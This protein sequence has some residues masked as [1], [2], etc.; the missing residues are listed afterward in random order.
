MS[1]GRSLIIIVGIVAIAFAITAMVYPRLPDQ[2]AS[3]WNARGKV[4]GWTGKGLGVFILPVTML[5]LTM[6]F[7]LLPLIDPLKR[8]IASFRPYYD[9]FI[10]VFLAFL[11]AI[12]VQV[13]LWNLGRQISP[14]RFLPI[15]MGLLIYYAGVLIQHAK[16]NWFIG[17][18]TPWTLSSDHV[19]EKTHLITGVLF[20]I[21][22]ALTVVGIA[23]EEH[24][25]WLFIV[26]LLATTVFSVAY[27]YVLYR[28]EQREAH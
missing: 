14:N 12:Q 13:L 27:S 25:L 8:N 11:L 19:W 3:H 28:N 22:G 5:G 16:R 20:K 2:V 9:T 6:L 23:F 7:M 10:I 17:V 18:R 24:W 26:P 21:C 4:D 1:T 15:P